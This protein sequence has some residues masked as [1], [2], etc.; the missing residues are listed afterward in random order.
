MNADAL[1]KKL[2]RLHLVEPSQVDECLSNSHMTQR[3]SDELLRLLEQKH[4]LTSY[5][6]GRIRKEELDGLVLD[7]YKLLYRN[8]SGSFARV[9]RACSVSNGH[10]VGLKLLRRRWA[11]DRQSI[12]LFHREA[13]LGMKLKHKNIVPIYEVGQK[14]DFH[15]FTMEFIEGAN[16]RDFIKIRKKLSPL[17]ATRYALDMSEGLA[18]AL[19]LGITHRDLKRTNVL[20]N[21]KGVAKLVDFGLAT[22]EQARFSQGESFQRAIEYAAL[23]NGTK[24][25]D[26]DPRTDLFFLGAIYYEL[27]TGVPPFAGGRTREERKKISRYT[28]VRPI[29]SLE[30]EIPRSVIAIVERLMKVN[31]ALRYQSAEEVARNLKSLLQDF[32][33]ESESIPVER[34]DSSTRFAGQR[35]LPTIMC[36]ERRAKQQDLLRD[37]LSK[38]GFRVLVLSDLQRG[39]NRLE[40]NP[41]ECVV[42]MGESIGERVIGGFQQMSMTDT[43]HPLVC[44][45]ILGEDQAAWKEDLVETTT[46]RIMVQPVTLRDLRKEIHLAFQRRKRNAG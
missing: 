35:S 44:I 26:D 5:Q 40:A 24:A 38:H 4:Y 31:P 9:F 11:Q 41:P 43:D 10:M 33:D 29:E 13:E 39:L 8:A 46:A 15:Y 6:V 12:A 16:L 37:Y 28:N 22:I 21:N 36:I 18:Y 27:L 32:G 42:L 2:V 23:E 25:P 17:E 45:A 1:G 30:P 34:Q 19:N 3:T 14:N 20:L 7:D